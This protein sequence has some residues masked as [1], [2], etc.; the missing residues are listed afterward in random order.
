MIGLAYT[1][2][3]V[4]EDAQHNIDVCVYVRGS[5]EPGTELVVTLSTSDFTAYG[6]Q[7]FFFTAE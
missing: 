4:R 2:Y 1:S 5:I 6:M 7:P 3:T